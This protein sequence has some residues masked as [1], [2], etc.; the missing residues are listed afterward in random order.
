MQ[1]RLSPNGNDA[2]FPLPFP[3]P[4]FHF[5]SPPLRL[6]ALSIPFLPS[7]EVW[8]QSPQLWGPGVTPGKK[9]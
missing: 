6:P 7:P 8:G 9:N 5:L 2:N 1:G 3:S 4:S